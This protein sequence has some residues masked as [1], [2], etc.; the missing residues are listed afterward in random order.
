MKDNQE[1]NPATSRE[2]LT[3]PRQQPHAGW[4][5]S[6]VVGE[7]VSGCLTSLARNTRRQSSLL[8]RHGREE[9]K[10]SGVFLACWSVLSRVVT[11]LQAGGCIRHE[12][13]ASRRA[14][15][16]LEPCGVPGMHACSEC[17]VAD[18]NDTRAVD[19]FTGSHQQRAKG[20]GLGLGF[21]RAMP[22]ARHRP[23]NGLC[24]P[25]THFRASE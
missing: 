3:R 17:P 16:Y 2:S 6:C 9:S 19:T 1:F 21:L 18:S 14:P 23:H 12:W 25:G 15:L 5:E 22:N 20:F 13:A 11:E 4:A 8:A 7:S 24:G 10:G